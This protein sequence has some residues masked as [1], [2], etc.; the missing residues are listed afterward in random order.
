MAAKAAGNRWPIDK[1]S[2]KGIGYRLF[3]LFSDPNLKIDAIL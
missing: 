1:R 2:F 3:S